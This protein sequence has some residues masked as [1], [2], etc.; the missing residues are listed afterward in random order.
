MPGVPGCAT[1]CVFSGVVVSLGFLETEGRRG[2]KG[3]GKG[4]ADELDSWPTLAG[5][6]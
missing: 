6:T 5:P 2:R 4:K 3:G 1:L